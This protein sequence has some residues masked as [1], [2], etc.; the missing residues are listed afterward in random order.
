MKSSQAGYRRAVKVL[1]R[2]RRNIK[3]RLQRGGQDTAVAM[4]GRESVRYDVAERT[5]AVAAG[6]LG[7][8]TQLVSRLGLDAGIN[9]NVGRTNDTG[10]DDASEVGHIGTDDEIPL[11]AI[12]ITIRY[13]D[14]SSNQMRQMTLVQ[15][16]V[17]E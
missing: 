15:S 6:G 13:Y 1:R 12:Q 7:V 5:R 10:T 14:L 17:N 11:R 2:E 9:D 4:L 8:A 3:R 16:L